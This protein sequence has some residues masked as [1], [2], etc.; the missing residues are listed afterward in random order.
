M[1]SIAMYMAAS[2]CGG[3]LRNLINRSVLPFFLTESER[4]APHVPVLVA[5]LALFMLWL[6]CHA[7]Y[8]Q[9]VFFKL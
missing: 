5:C 7:L 3:N 4:A 8:R 1:N 2:L 6:F 9:K